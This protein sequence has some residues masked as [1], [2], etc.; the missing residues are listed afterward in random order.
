MS[1]KIKKR[2]GIWMDTHHATIIGYDPDAAIFTVLGHAKNPGAGS[3]S[4]ENAANHLEITLANKY[5]KEIAHHLVN[6]DEVHITGSGTIQE[7]FVR[8]LGDTPQFKKTAASQST[9]TPMSD[10][11]LVEFITSHFK[12]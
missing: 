11:K 5:F 9:S 3:N 7:Q 6:A 10:E 2:F 4:N 12:N 8:Y 1:D